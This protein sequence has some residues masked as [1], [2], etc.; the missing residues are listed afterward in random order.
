MTR[1]KQV[2]RLSFST[3]R[4]EIKAKD[5]DDGTFVLLANRRNISSQ[6]VN[7]IYNKL[8]EDKH[9]DSSFIV[10][11]RSRAHRL[12]DGNHRY[13]AV[14]KYLKENPN[15]RVEVLL[16]IYDNL[17]D[18]QEKELY[19]QY[20]S[21]RKQSTKDF[22]QQYQDDIPIFKEIC[23]QT[24]FPVKVSVYGGQGFLK[25]DTLVSAYLE[26]KK[27][28][29]TGG[30]IGK[31]WDFVAAAKELGHNDV[32]LMSAFMKDFLNSFGPILNNK[33]TKTTPL[34]AL[35]R[36]WTEKR[37]NIYNEKMVKAFRTKLANNAAAIDM[38]RMSG[39]SNCMYVRDKYLML[40]NTGRIKFIDGDVIT[41]DPAD[42]ED[43]DEE[44]Y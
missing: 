38:C 5:M 41:P 1:K 29:F 20:N 39:K 7:Q 28:R 21:G 34:Y 18:A 42:D 2:L 4:Y 15:N 33:W 9:F 19:T 32:K 16:H 12:I 27:P 3:K 35:M 17:D 31:P 24:K 30:W 44:S 6:V 25:F 14:V 37:Q 43:E 13:E 40:L 23:D 11:K 36:I 10:N 22:V 26:S 8:L